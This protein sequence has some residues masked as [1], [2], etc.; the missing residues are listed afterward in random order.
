MTLCG[1]LGGAMWRSCFPSRT[2]VELLEA[3]LQRH[4]VPYRLEGGRGFYARQEVRDL[5]SLLEAIDDP[6]DSIAIVAALRSLAF[7]C[8]DDDL[9]LWRVANERFDYRCIG[10]DGPASVRESLEVMADL[11]RA[12]RS[13]SLG[14][15]V[16]LAVERSG[17]VEAALTVPG[18]DQAAANVLKVVDVAQEFAGAGGGALRGFTNWLVR[19]RDEE[20]REVDA[21]VAEER[22]DIVRIM[23][24]HAAKGLEFPIVALANVEW[25]GT[26]AG[27]ADPGR[28]QPSDSP[29]RGQRLGA[30]SDARLGGREGVRE[31]GARGR[32]RSPALRRCHARA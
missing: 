2:R 18:G 19:N 23:T 6:A 1:R 29:D 11:H 16:R 27:A 17:L 32:A 30:F 26:E 14:D 3:A 21:P 10:K 31:G 8:S 15:L 7:G 9:L 24:I 25:D 4:G 12:Q 5:I 22:D 20:E 28:G 13:F